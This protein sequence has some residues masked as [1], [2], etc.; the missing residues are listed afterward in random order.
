[1][2][3]VGLTIVILQILLAICPVLHAG[4]TDEGEWRRVGSA[5]TTWS[6]T[7]KITVVGNAVL[8]PV[9]LTHGIN[10]V[11]ALLLLDTGSSYTVVNRAIVERLNINL[12]QARKKRVQVVGGA[13]LD[14][15]GVTLSDITVGPHS[16]RD[17]EILII[18]H[19]GQ[20]VKFDGLL[21]MDLLRTMKYNIDLHGQVLNW[22]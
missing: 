19:R 2:A 9:A 17:A 7:T 3:G 11:E 8:V 10:Q 18:E 15:Y 12:K 13:L 14:A 1:M 6:S 5:V 4:E 22:E 21:G 16:K 20:P